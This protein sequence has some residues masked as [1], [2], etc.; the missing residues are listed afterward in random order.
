MPSSGIQTSGTRHRHQ[1]K[2]ASPDAFGAL[3]EIARE[4]FDGLKMDDLTPTVGD[5]RTDPTKKHARNATT[6]LNELSKITLD[7]LALHGHM[8]PERP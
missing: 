2:Q 8:R 1:P 3:H 6:V 5:V 4:H 7:L